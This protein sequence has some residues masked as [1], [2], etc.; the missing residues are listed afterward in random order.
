[1]QETARVV[2]IGGGVTG[3]AILYHLAKAGWTDVVLLE[4][5]ELTAGS[6]WHAAGSLF[7]MTTPSNAS[8]LQKYTQD[9]YPEL[10]KESGQSCGFHR[11][12]GLLL[13]R[14]PDQLTALQLAQSRAKRVGIEAE[15]ISIAEAKRL[16]PILNTAGIEAVVFEPTRGFCDPASVTQAYAKAARDRGAKVHRHRPVTGLK[17]LPSG[18]WEVETPKGAI[19]AQYVVNAAGLW[20]REVA[21]MAGITLPLM[22]VEHHYMVTETIPEIAALDHEIPNIAEAGAGYYCRQEGT[23][24]RARAAHPARRARAP[25]PRRWR[26]LAARVALAEGRVAA[27]LAVDHPPVAKGERAVAT[28]PRIPHAAEPGM[29]ILGA[30]RR[31]APGHEHLVVGRAVPRFA[32]CGEL[33]AVGRGAGHGGERR[34]RE[35]PASP[36]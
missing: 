15:F 8:V 16:A 23:P 10:E 36:D 19:R 11:T 12:G 14:T 4:R 1:M 7:G 17:L 13:V 26:S 28:R 3:C 30:M 21:A 32:R 24:A 6:S 29:G 22:P 35:R 2:V 34:Q 18:E 31:R 9:L 20:G 5:S 27:P 25:S 33:P